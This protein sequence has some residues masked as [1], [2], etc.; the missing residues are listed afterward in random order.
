MTW[1]RNYYRHE[2]CNVQPGIEWNDCADSMCNDRCPAC[3]AEIEPE[4]SADLEP[5][6]D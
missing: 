2:D 5:E 1:F 4:D 3:R 6:D